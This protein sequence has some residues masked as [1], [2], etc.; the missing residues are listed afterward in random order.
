MATR[1][2]VLT[3]LQEWDG[4]ALQARVLLV[5]RGSPLDPLTSG[6]PSFAEAKFVLDA[7]V[8]A[9]LDGMPTPA[10]ATTATIDLG[11][12]PTSKQVFDAL[13]TVYQINPTPPPTSPRRASTFI[14]K[15]LPLTYQAAAKSTGERSQ[16]VFTDD[17]YSCALSTPPRKPFVSFPPPDPKVPWGK[18]IAFIMR[19]PQ[20]AEQAGLIRSITVPVS[21]PVDL[22][23]GGWLY[24][25]LD[26]TSHG[27]ALLGTPDGL[28][29][30]AA[31]IPALSDPRPLF[32]PVLFPVVAV[33]SG[34]S[35][36][37]L[38]AEVDD[39]DNGFAKAVHTVQSKQLDPLQEQPDGTRPAKELGVRIGWDDEQVTIWLNR[40]IDPAAAD[41]DAPMGVFGYRIDVREHAEAAW[42]SLNLATG[43]LRAGSFDGGTFSGELG[44]ET[45]AVQLDGDKT[46]D[47]W[48]PTYFAAWTGP[49]LVGLDA[50]QI[51]IAN[52]PD[53]RDSGRVQPVQPDISLRYGKT[54]DFRVR[55]MDHTGG[56]PRTDENPAVAGP[57]PTS[58]IPVRRWIRPGLAG[59]TDKVPSTPD[60]A[61]PPASLHFLRPLLGYPAVVL[62]GAYADPVQDL[63]NDLPAAK[64][65]EREPGLFDQDVTALK[66]VVEAQG[67][68]QDPNADAGGFVPLYETT[69]NFTAG[70]DDTLEVNLEYV[71]VQDAAT[72]DAPSGSLRLPTART[73]RIRYSAVCRNDAHNDYFGA[74]DVR[75]GPSRMLEVRKESSDERGLF[76]ADA[77]AHRFSAVFLQP[78][79]PF[80]T[81][82]NAAQFFAGRGLERPSDVATRF[83]AHFNLRNDG[84]AMRAQP[85]RRVIFGASAVLRHV[86]GPD[87]ASIA[88]ASQSDLT[89]H[90]LVV[91][92][93]TLDRDWTWDGLN[94]DGF[95]VERDGRQVGRF[96][97]T[98]SVGSDALLEPQRTQTDLIFIDAVDPKPEPGAF[99]RELNLSYTIRSA[100]RSNGAAQDPPLDLAIRLPITTPPVQRPKIVSVGIALSPYQR[101]DDYHSS[102]PRKKALWIEFDQA[103][104][105]PHD[106][107]FA[108][109]LRNV[110]DPLLANQIEGVPETGEPPLPVD[111]EWIR[112]VIHGQSD[113]RAGLSAMQP[114]PSSE[115]PVHYLLPLPAG[116]DENS[117]E[118]FGF[119]TYEFR[120]GH[121]EGW[122]TAQGRY[123]V[124]LRVTG[125][126]HP[127]PE[128]SCAVGRTQAG[129][130][131]SALFATA[132]WD[133]RNIQAIPPRTSLWVLLYAQAKQVDSADFRNV[134]LA[135]K[136]ARWVRKGDFG[137]NEFT[138]S[139]SASAAGPCGTATFSDA[140]IRAALQA[141]TFRNDAPISVL[142]VELLPEVEERPD[143]VG[144]DLGSQR[145]LRTS[146]LTA[147]PAIC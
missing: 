18:V 31:R 49:S 132:I 79:P 8:V 51:R 7:R 34:S 112:S 10:A 94:H 37:D 140:E 80:E 120:C 16:Y 71:D 73:V 128:L 145:I 82:V 58:T 87:G 78:D 68:A 43:P 20:L 139:A 101:S 137:R 106:A 100:L 61:N 17:S 30:Y 22:G 29:V 129:V 42:H 83:A 113:D 93:L 111:P 14:K 126:Q 143:P 95:V 141:L 110:P 121:L 45:H 13:E 118:L 84:L 147:V 89:Q 119:Y 108:R 67:V 134:L 64:A 90:W 127:A 65:E 5:P 40:Q 4:S 3:Y 88:F 53:K 41:L 70:F 98:R 26:V 32:T 69:R 133:G 92:R 107:Y 39:Y 25:T 96:G 36:D 103:P 144:A 135:R 21:P 114:L 48:L 125:V 54:Y 23:A 76:A 62:T 86:L 44:V 123:G 72:L 56:G 81:V 104:N 59:I 11:V 27:A 115:S 102:E 130:T 6:V 60:P 146:P 38:F 105:D 1:L 138:G 97:L 15:H 85:G 47:F 9:G 55:L 131:A 122:S 2:S 50:D 63:L 99:P 24:V 35:Y 116:V 124:P 66:F 19:N 57:S 91:I 75:F 46:G 52:G 12:S 74:D 142:A 109:V 28:K 117:P 136:L 77:A 33:P